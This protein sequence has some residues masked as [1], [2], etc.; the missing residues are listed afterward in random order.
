M[1]IIEG[2]DARPS[3][4]P[5]LKAGWALN[6][7]LWATRKTDYVIAQDAMAHGWWFWT[8]RIGVARL[9]VYSVWGLNIRIVASWVP[10]K[11]TVLKA[12]ESF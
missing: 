12:K 3:A 7:P 6:L 1:K 2:T 10:S 11:G 5:P 9:G 8:I 4:N